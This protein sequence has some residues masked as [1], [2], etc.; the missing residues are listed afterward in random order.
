VIVWRI[1][2][3]EFARSPL[4]VEGAKAWPGRW[5]SAGTAVLYTAASESLALLEKFVH[6]ALEF[7][8]IPH[9]KLCIELPADAQVEKLEDLG[10]P[11][12][13]WR[14]D[15][16]TTARAAG[17]RWA[18][19]SEAL[20]LSVPSVLSSSERNVLL[21][22]ASPQ[23]GQ[24]KILGQEEFLYDERMWKGETRAALKRGK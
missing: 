24:L 14:S 11:L 5:H 9:V 21:R 1:I 23:F 7:R 18:R 12:P 6:L 13:D 3:K 15:D 2:R 22:A 17:D 16:P 10:D 19:Q 8:T 4:S 20:G